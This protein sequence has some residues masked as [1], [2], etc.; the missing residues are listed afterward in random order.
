MSRDDVDGARIAFSALLDADVKPHV[1]WFALLQ[2]AVNSA[3]SVVVGVFGGTHAAGLTRSVA[4]HFLAAALSI[5]LLAGCAAVAI[6]VRPHRNRARDAWKFWALLGSVVVASLSQLLSFTLALRTGNDSDSFKGFCAALAFVVVISCACLFVALFVAYARALGSFDIV[7]VLLVRARTACAR[8]RR[9]A[10]E[11]RDAAQH[12]AALE[13]AGSSGSPPPWRDVEREAA[14]SDPP[15][16]WCD[17]VFASAAQS[18]FGAVVGANVATSVNNPLLQE[19]SA[20]TRTSS[21]MPQGGGSVQT[22]PLR[23]AITRTPDSMFA[24]PPARTGSAAPQGGGSVQ[25]NPLRSAATRTP[26]SMFAAP[27]ARTGS[28]APRGGGSVQ[29]NPLRSA[30]TRTPDSMFAARAADTANPLHRG[31]P[32]L[33]RAAVSTRSSDVVFVTPAAPASMVYDGI[34][35]YNPEDGGAWM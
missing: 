20:P 16:P 27:P 31:A 10:A 15:P 6:A 25:T 3:M 29:T 34:V 22:N 8:R 5:A 30:A 35:V 7:R 19:N 33:R 9:R 2:S 18:T 13:L 14:D 28:A 24:A 17:A 21:V 26:D 1:Y 23:S 32:H 11:K 4:A 12:A